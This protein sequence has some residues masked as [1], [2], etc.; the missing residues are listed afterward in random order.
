MPHTWCPRTPAVL[1]RI[2]QTARSTP[3]RRN[4]YVDLLRA[5]AI[6]LVVL[7]HWL[8]VVVTNDDGISGRNALGELAWS[9]PLTWLFQVMPVFF[10]VGGYANAASLISHRDRGGD[11][12]GWVLGRT[13]RL[14]RPTS[15]FLAAVW[16]VAFGALLLDVPPEAVGLAVWAAA[17]PLWFLAVYLCVVVLAPVTHGLHRRWGAAVP[18]VLVGIVLVLDAARLGFGVPIVGAANYLLVWLTM[19]QLGYLWRDRLARPRPLVTA[20]AALSG[21]AL[22]LGLT[23]LGP[24]PISMVTVPGQEFGNTSPPTF[25]LLVLGLTQTAVVLWLARPARRLLRRPRPWTAV[26]AVNSVVLTVF[27][28]HMS[29]A[30]ITGAALYGTGLLAQRPVDSAAWLLQRVPWLVS[31][32]WCWRSSWSPS[33][34]SRHAPPPPAPDGGS[35]PRRRSEPRPGAPCWCSP[36]SRWWPDSPGSP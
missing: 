17:I 22:L 16:A 23:V 28:W 3:E 29:A 21:C 26:V 9:Q 34:A 7:G 13:D 12:L 14:L 24:Y 18:L 27:L 33:A 31:V 5:L 6:V 30:V 4:R 15:A 10:L 19:H 20:M 36:W 1:R 2:R 35:G 8:A 25:A 32:A 11:A